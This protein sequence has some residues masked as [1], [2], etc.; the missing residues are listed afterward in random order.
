MQ[1]KLLVRFDGKDTNTYCGAGKFEN[2]G[3]NVTINFNSPFYTLGGR[4]LCEI[5]TIE[6][7]EDNCQCG[8]KDLVSMNLLLQ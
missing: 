4:F 5:K 1:D 8:W 7:D 3:I 2:K 6:F